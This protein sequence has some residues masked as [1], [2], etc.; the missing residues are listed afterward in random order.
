MPRKKKVF[1]YDVIKVFHEKE[2]NA[3][4]KVK[5]CIMRWSNAHYA[6]LE[7][8]RFFYDEYEDKWC[9]WKVAGITKDDFKIVMEKKD[10]IMQALEE[11]Q[12]AIDKEKE[13]KKRLKEEEKQR[14][15][16]EEAKKKAE[17]K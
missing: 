10:E 13:E 2:V 8:R 12:A 15:K 4:N 6:V 5:L 1:T 3:K 11:A 16:E 7:N 14:K 9:P 17:E